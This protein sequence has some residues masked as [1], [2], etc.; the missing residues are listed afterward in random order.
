MVNLCAFRR[1]IRTRASWYHHRLVIYVRINTRHTSRGHL[2]SSIS[3]FSWVKLSSDGDT[4]FFLHRN[5]FLFRWVA[6]LQLWCF[7]FPHYCHHY[8]Y[9]HHCL[10]HHHYHDQMQ[11]NQYHHHFHPSLGL[12]PQIHFH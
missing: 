1:H 8:C 3:S 9:Y 2:I 12:L 4:S 10:H 11:H 7:H 6:I 5:T